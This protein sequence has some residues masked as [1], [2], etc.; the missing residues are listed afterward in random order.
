MGNQAEAASECPSRADYG[1][2]PAHGQRNA[3]TPGLPRLGVQLDGLGHGARRD[4]E[5]GR[6][7][8]LWRRP[9]CELSGTRSPRI[10]RRLVSRSNRRCHRPAA[11][12]NIPTNE[13][14]T[15][16]DVRESHMHDH[17]LAL[18]DLLDRRLRTM[19][20]VGPISKP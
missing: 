10:D 7:V 13:V 3:D 1:N 5:G 12:W 14:G 19:T 17:E 18:R 20:T 15:I 11:V 2:V 6:D 16:A 9:A 8:A 4:V